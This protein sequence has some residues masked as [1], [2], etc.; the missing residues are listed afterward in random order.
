MYRRVR[1]ETGDEGGST[2]ADGIAVKNVSEVTHDIVREYVDDIVLVSE[3]QIEH[4]IC[5][6]LNIEKTLAEGAG[7]ASLA[8]V[9]ADRQRFAGRCVGVVLSG[10]NIDHRLLATVLLRNLFREGKLARFHIVINDTPG[11]L[12]RLTTLIELHG[13]NIVEMAHQRTFSHHRA[14]EATVEVAIET[15]NWAHT[16]ATVNRILAAGYSVQLLENE[17]LDH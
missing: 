16:E 2:I 6:Y 17:Q 5:L 15:R 3:E 13:A 12:G 14:R 7:A 8:A 11:E 10:G 9:L 4:A 1:G